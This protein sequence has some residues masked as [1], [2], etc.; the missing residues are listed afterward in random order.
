[1]AAG[2]AGGST[3]CAAALEGLNRLWQL[4]LS[5]HSR[6]FTKMRVPDIIAAIL[7]ENGITEFE[8]RLGKFSAAEI[9]AN[10]LRFGAERFKQQFRAY[11]EEQVKQPVRVERAVG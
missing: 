4:G 11:V 3:D 10:S 9:R 7:Q 2:L 5:R 1:M 6:I 8:R